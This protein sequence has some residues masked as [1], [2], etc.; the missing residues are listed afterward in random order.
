[1][2]FDK[3]REIRFKNLI[4]Y[5]MVFFCAADSGLGLSLLWKGALEIHS[6]RF[7]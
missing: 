7:R 5:F 4:T 6:C 2:I 1:M 3:I